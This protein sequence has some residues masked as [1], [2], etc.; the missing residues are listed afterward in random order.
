MK[1]GYHRWKGAENA[2]KTVSGMCE[3]EGVTRRVP[4]PVGG[5]AGT[6]GGI[7]PPRVAGGVG[8]V[9]E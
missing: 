2:H 3:T 5:R 7:G 9:A 1:N 8:G 6:R 4:G